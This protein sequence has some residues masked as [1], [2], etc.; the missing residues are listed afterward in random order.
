M[1]RPFHELASRSSLDHIPWQPRQA[2]CLTPAPDPW[3]APPLHPQHTRIRDLEKPREEWKKLPCSTRELFSHTYLER[4]SDIFAEGIM[5]LL[6]FSKL[7][8]LEHLL[9]SAVFI[10]G[11][12]LICIKITFR[13]LQNFTILRESTI[14]ITT[15]T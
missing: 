9:F 14:I 8:D 5:H 12:P 13:L 4:N 3:E 1:N 6:S 7:S 15:I 11:Q 10:R 2:G